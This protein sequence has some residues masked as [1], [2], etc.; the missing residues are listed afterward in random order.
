MNAKHMRKARMVV[1]MA[2]FCAMGYSNLR[3]AENT[4]SWTGP[5][6]ATGNT[7]WT[8]NNSSFTPSTN[9]LLNGV[10]AVPPQTPAVGDDTILAYGGAL[11]IGTSTQNA[12][13]SST[14]PA[15]YTLFQIV[16]NDYTTSNGGSLTLTTTGA[17][18]RVINLGAG[19]IVDN[20]ASSGSI[21]ITNASTATDNRLNLTVDQTW[22][23]NSP[24]NNNF[25][26][27]RAISGS[28]SLTKTGT[29]TL[30][31]NA[32]SAAFTGTLNL[33]QGVVRFDAD[34]SLANL[35]DFSNIS[36][37]E[38][39]ITCS[40][41]ANETFACP[42]FLGG[43][44][45]LDF[46]GTGNA[47]FTNS[48]TLSSMKRISQGG[49]G[50][51]TRSLTFSGPISGTGGI[52][53]LSTGSLI[54][55]G[56]NSY[57]GDTQVSNGTLSINDFSELGTAMTP[58]ILGGTTVGAGLVIRAANQSTPRGL[59]INPFGASLDFAGSLTVG[60]IT[61]ASVASGTLTKVGT[62]ILTTGA[63]QIGTLSATTGAVV[64][65]PSAGTN[66][67]SNL[68]LG[69]GTGAWTSKLD[70][71][72]NSLIVDYTGAANSPLGVVADQLKSGYAS[73]SWTGQGITSGAAAT[74][75]ASASVNKTAL[76]YAEA[77]TLG[78]TTFGG[79]PV[80]SDAV[81]VKYTLAGDANLDG[82]VNALD[83]NAVATNFGLAGQW[84]S[85][86]FDYN[87]VV[88]S[89]DFVAIAQNFGLSISPTPA[90]GAVVPEPVTGASLMV[91]S[92]AAI[93]RRR[94]WR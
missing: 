53:K 81:V 11:S 85:G 86:D 29:G 31:L 90:L 88:G 30:D 14:N 45:T 56:S 75:A 23:I 91:L 58:I 89:S 26:V 39:T 54:F 25:I 4:Y 70:L 38:S 24:A 47:T 62:G 76:G 67:V 35:G 3:A 27:K 36:D 17:G 10:N 59:T 19:G 43:A 21:L 37:N 2:A 1:A 92:I 78:I 94:R 42:A 32:V 73:G 77:S 6:S 5:A 71:N 34:N 50:S 20:A 87:G 16:I 12:V 93:A 52:N 74:I 63:I 65:A 15:D 40:G 79:L 18:S 8:L 49:T 72:N 44:G 48:V 61:G 69:G 22:S 7:S 68:I 64:T 66:Q 80:D 33:Q 13:G 84:S 41:G 83:F 46:S 55:S 28:A 57:S 60:A 51:A 82:V 9:W